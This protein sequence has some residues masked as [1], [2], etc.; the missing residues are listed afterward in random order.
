MNNINQYI[1]EYSN[2]IDEKPLAF[3]ITG[4]GMETF[5]LAQT[6][7]AS[8]VLTSI[9]VP[10]HLE[11]SVKF[12]SENLSELEGIKFKEKA[13]SDKSAELLCKAGMKKWPECRIIAVTGAGTTTRYR[14]GDNQA[15]ISCGELLQM[16]KWKD[17]EASVVF[18]PKIDT[19]HIMLPKLS[20][21][22]H[23]NSSTEDI[24]LLRI[25]EDQEISDFVLKLAF[26]KINKI[27]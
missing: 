25:K 6:L 18:I 1:T 26:K 24:N 11:Q 16:S 7:G 9:F 15:Y 5:K 4:I 21:E 2:K 10:Y 8:K 17:N 22:E 27:K 14:R 20:E 3:I 23:T 19:F 12:I 13:V